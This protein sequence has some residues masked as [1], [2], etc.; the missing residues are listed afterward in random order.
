[1]HAEL[2]LLADFFTFKQLPDED[3]QT[4]LIVEKEELASIHSHGSRTMLPLHILPP[5]DEVRGVQE[6]VS[7]NYVIVRSQEA[8]FHAVLFSFSMFLS[9]IVA[10][11]YLS[12]SLHL[13]YRDT[14]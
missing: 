6:W 12:L 10:A 5:S 13:P 2:E 9:A 8:I 11:I 4:P 7:D 3:E 1:M 14:L